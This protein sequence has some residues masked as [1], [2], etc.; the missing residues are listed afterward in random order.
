MDEQNE[1]MDLD[2]EFL[3]T[4]LGLRIPTVAAVAV[5]LAVVPLAAVELPEVGN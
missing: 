4:I 3:S 2:T 5:G 1:E